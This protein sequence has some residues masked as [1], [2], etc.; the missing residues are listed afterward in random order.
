MGE[1][2]SYDS[3]KYLDKK[4]EGWH[5]VRRSFT[6]DNISYGDRAVEIYFRNNSR[7]FFGLIR[8]EHQKDIPYKHSKLVEK[9]MTDKEFRGNHEAPWSKDVWLKSWK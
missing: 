8:F 7:T 6:E 4:G 2:W 9:V 3:T 1:L 5:F